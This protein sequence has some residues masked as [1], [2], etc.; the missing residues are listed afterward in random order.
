MRTRH[1]FQKTTLYDI[2]RRS[3]LITIIG[4]LLQLLLLALVAIVCR[5]RVDK[6]KLTIHEILL[7]IFRTQLNSKG[8]PNY[9]SEIYY[10]RLEYLHMFSDLCARELKEEIEL[11]NRIIN[12]YRALSQRRTFL[13]TDLNPHRRLNALKAERV[14][15]ID[16][17]SQ[18][19]EI[20]KL[21]KSRLRKCH[22]LK[23][24]IDIDLQSKLFK[25]PADYYGSREIN[26][27]FADG[28]EI[29][30]REMELLGDMCEDGLKRLEEVTL[31][32]AVIEY[33]IDIMKGSRPPI[34]VREDCGL[35]Y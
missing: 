11:Q 21:L 23:L 19:Q 15:A 3:L 20:V 34:E 25:Q 18:I 31:P 10:Q 6:D 16:E 22:I 30:L 5:L 27:L 17:L 28:W 4:A 9:L 13:L 33:E 1:N 7:Q 32:E 26:K 29:E 24:D 8:V 35:E 12:L 2:Q 14:L